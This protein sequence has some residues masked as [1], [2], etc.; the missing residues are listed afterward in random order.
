MICWAVKQ[1]VP[2]EEVELFTLGGWRF[3]GPLGGSRNS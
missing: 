1:A 2:G 3:L